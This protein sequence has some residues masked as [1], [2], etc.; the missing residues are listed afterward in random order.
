MDRCN[1][2]AR[3]AD[4]ETEA[5]SARFRGRVAHDTTV[6]DD[7]DLPVIPI[8][9]GAVFV[10]LVYPRHRSRHERQACQR[11]MTGR[12]TGTGPDSKWRFSSRLHHNGAVLW[13]R[14]HAIDAQLLG[15]PVSL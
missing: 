1:G 6:P 14:E 3:P 2:A 8:F 5:R 15:I 9:E 12:R 7:A 4:N 11:G 13:L 10:L